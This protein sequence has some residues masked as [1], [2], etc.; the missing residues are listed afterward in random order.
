MLFEEPPIASDDTQPNLVRARQQ[1]SEKPVLPTWALIGV[2]LLSLF[3]LI[4]TLSLV[5]TYAESGETTIA[6]PARVAIILGG[7]RIDVQS[8]AASVGDLLS[9]Q[10]IVVN[11][12]DALSDPPQAPLVNDM[13]ITIDRARDVD[14]IINGQQR[15]IRTPFSNPHDILT[16]QNITLDSNDRIWLDGTATQLCELAAWPIPVLE[17]V[18]NH[19]MRITVVDGEEEL[20]LDSTAQTV[21]DALFEADVPVY[22]TDIV[23]PDV[24]TALQEG[25]RITIDRAQ[26]VTIH[27]D[28]T[29]LETRAQAGTIA[30]AL[31]DAGIALIGLDYTI[32]QENIPIESGMN[33]AVIRVTEEIE[34]FDEPVPYETILQADAQMP[35]DARQVLQAGQNGISRLSERVRYENGV[36]VAR[37][38][39]GTEMIQA[40]VNEVVAYG[41][42]VVLRTIDTPDGPREYWRKLRVYATSY[43]PE[44]LGG[45]NIT[46]IG[47]TLQ[48][49][50]IGGDPQLIPYR[51]NL[52][53]PGY[54]T[55]ILAD[56]GGARSTQY[57]IDLGYSDEDWVSWSRYVD[58]YLLTPIPQNINYLLPQ[59]QPIRGIPDNG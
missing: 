4:A 8:S 51:T 25:M 42:N 29:T 20:T 52:Y 2:I 49:G 44:A 38:P 36:E 45:D 41:T 58:V 54:G 26:P 57:W 14:L 5:G 47:E 27:V 32:P 21:G 11:A 55:G 28:G 17:I 1:I 23:E 33:I 43:H 10:N 3:S 50:I 35:L 31:T 13:V 40:P 53:V 39:A 59:W 48:K 19:T 7:E 6:G 46:A 15:T 34:T 12:A 24:S 22:L 30:D 16:Q 56:T 37:E 9:E 18:V